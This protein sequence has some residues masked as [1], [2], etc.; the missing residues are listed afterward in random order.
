MKRVAIGL[1]ILALA[2]GCAKGPSSTEI[3]VLRREV[4]EL[5]AKHEA[6]VKQLAEIEMRQTGWIGPH[7][8]VQRKIETTE[9][10][11]SAKFSDLKDSHEFVT[12]DHAAKID[13]LDHRLQ[14]LEARRR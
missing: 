11:L 13:D 14:T 9:E 8:D 3:A 7:M 1:L 4:E 6:V 5:R 2:S 10:L 12:K